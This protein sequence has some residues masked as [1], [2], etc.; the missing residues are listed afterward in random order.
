M[1]EFTVWL[2]DYRG[3]RS[4]VLDGYS[5]LHIVEVVNGISVCSVDIPATLDRSQFYP[6]R[7]VEVEYSRDGET[8]RLEFVG[9]IR[10]VTI[11]DDEGVDYLHLVC[12]SPEYL[13]DGRI[14]A[15]SA[16]SAQASMNGYAD[17][18]IKAVVR[19]NLGSDAGSGRD[20]SS[21]GV[22]VAGNLSDAPEVTKAFAWRNLLRVIQDIC[23][24]S[25][26]RGTRLFF[27]FVP[28]IQT[29]V[30]FVFMTYTGCIGRDRGSGSS[31]QLRFGQ[32][33]GNLENPVLR[34]NW[35]D[36]V[37]YIYAGGQGEGSDRVIVTI[38]DTYRIKMSP[39]NRREAFADARNELSTDGVT[40]KARS[41]LQA[42]RPKIEFNGVLLD[43]PVSRY[44]TDWSLGDIVI[45]EYADVSFDGLVSRVEIDVS[46]SAV[47]IKGRFTV[48]E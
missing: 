23:D 46:N 11:Y 32:A 17:D 16:G 36:E 37:N 34:Y 22:S 14:V 1:I 27:G 43:S 31:D 15:Y 48:V 26:Q 20:L 6:D 39:W 45:V 4:A 3:R 5:E 30:G 47:E 10:E 25:A 9:F 12:Y 33:W 2:C 44:G 42:G 21:L 40:T 13:L 19:D 18:I 29:E 35:S 7:I 28:V 24:A 38:G 41:A 8:S